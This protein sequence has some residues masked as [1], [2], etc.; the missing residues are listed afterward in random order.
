MLGVE[1]GGLLGIFNCLGRA[2]AG[3]LWGCEGIWLASLGVLP[4]HRQTSGGSTEVAKSHVSPV[5]MEP[6]H[7]GLVKREDFSCL[8]G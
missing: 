5:H 8:R 6:C 4:H 1:A 7:L 2:G 3:T